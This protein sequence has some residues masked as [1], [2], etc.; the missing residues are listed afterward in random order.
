M[1]CTLCA[2][3]RWWPRPGEVAPI[4]CLPALA[5]ALV[6]VPA[7]AGAEP[8]EASVRPEGSPVALSVPVEYHRTPSALD[9]ATAVD[10]ARPGSTP[11]G[12]QPRGRVV[13]RTLP[14][15]AV[16]QLSR[17]D[18]RLLS[19]DR[20]DPLVVSRSQPG[21]VQVLGYDE[22]DTDDWWGSRMQ[23]V[24]ATEEAGE[25]VVDRLVLV[26]REG[27]DLIEVEFSCSTGC[28]ERYAEEID[29]IVSSWTTE[30]EP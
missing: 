25:V 20:I 4:R 29:R 21:A 9:G 8:T 19:A 6:L 12:A 17:R 28:F 22:V 23:V 14:V 15:E 3:S 30:D 11:G 7:C 16:D 2:S 18:L 24:L 13:H 10:L 26:G 27:G 5:A 1:C